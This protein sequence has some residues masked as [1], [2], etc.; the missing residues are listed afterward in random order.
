LEPVQSR[1]FGQLFGQTFRLSLHRFFKLL[2]IYL[3]F[4]VP[5]GVA[6]ALL[7]YRAELSDQVLAAI[8][9]GLVALVWPIPRAAVMMAVSDRFTG[10]TTSIRLA[11]RVAFHRGGTLIGV[12]LLV[13]VLV[14]VGLVFLL[15][16]GL[17]F[18][19]LFAVAEEVVVFE[20]RTLGQALARSCEL[21]RGRWL[22]ILFFLL[23]LALTLLVPMNVAAA[24][25]KA[26]FCETGF[27]A[28]AF[29]SLTTILFTLVMG[30]GTLCLYMSLRAE[31]DGLTGP[32]LA[33]QVGQVVES[34]PVPVAPR[35][36]TPKK[37][38]PE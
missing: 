4:M 35:K 14:G 11:F 12:G 28:T 18:L 25:V 21:A 17:I 8:F 33:D 34:L 3:M 23:V 7:S 30:V 19:V 1:A 31:K 16:P 26:V 29:E 24:V 5:I 32:D 13:K 20:N 2:T 6:E 22:F 37:P 38:R 27:I 15:I 10:N 9:S 36:S